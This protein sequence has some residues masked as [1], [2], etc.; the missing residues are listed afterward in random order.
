MSQTDYKTRSPRATSILRT[1]EPLRIRQCSTQVRNPTALRRPASDAPRQKQL[2][3]RSY[4]GKAI[5]HRQV[6][7]T[8]GW[9]RSLVTVTER[10]RLAN[11]FPSEFSPFPHMTKSDH[12]AGRLLRP[13]T[14]T[15]QP[16][17]QTPNRAGL[18][19]AEWQSS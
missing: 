14:R 2:L 5:C 13:A 10:L 9:A 18:A 19:L 3:V 11:H 6:V 12:S 8:D 1:Q 15:S 16:D 17:G 4:P 7:D